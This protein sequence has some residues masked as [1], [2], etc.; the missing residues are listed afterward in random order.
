MLH[1]LQEGQIKDALAADDTGLLAGL[2][3]ETMSSLIRICRALAQLIQSKTVQF[4]M[5]VGEARFPSFHEGAMQSKAAPVGHSF[6]LLTLDTTRSTPADLEAMKIDPHRLTPGMH[7][8]EATGWMDE[9][10]TTKEARISK[11]YEHRMHA[12]GFVG[13]TAPRLRTCT[14]LEQCDRVYCYMYMINDRM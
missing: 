5:V 1:A 7:V 4:A 8:I 3:P 13:D 14:T 11:V 2:A 9:F 12:R 6:G 10:K